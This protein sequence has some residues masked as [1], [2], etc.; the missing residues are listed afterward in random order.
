[1]YMPRRYGNE[2]RLIFSESLFFHLQN[3]NKEKMDMMKI[4]KLDIIEERRRDGYVHTWGHGMK[5]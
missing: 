1:M 5:Y 4:C 3:E 2:I